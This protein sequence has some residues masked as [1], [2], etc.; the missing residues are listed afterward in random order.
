[1][2]FQFPHNTLLRSLHPNSKIYFYAILMYYFVV[3]EGSNFIEIEDIFLHIKSNK[4][5]KYKLQI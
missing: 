2:P 3:I 4:T 1:M 5:N